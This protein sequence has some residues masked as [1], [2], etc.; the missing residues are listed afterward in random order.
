MLFCGLLEW[1]RQQTTG[2]FASPGDAARSLLTAIVVY[3]AVGGVLGCAALLWRSAAAGAGL[4]LVA[5]AVALLAVIGHEPRPALLLAALS[6][7]FASAWLVM[8]VAART[9][10]L[11]LPRVWWTSLAVLLAACVGLALQHPLGSGLAWGAAFALAALACLDLRSLRGSPR[12]ALAAVGLAVA[13]T[14]FGVAPQRVA[15]P[16]ESA[17]S[18]PSILLVTIDTLRADHVGAYGA[19]QART[20]NIDALALRG[21]RFEYAFSQNAFTAPS[22]SS[23]LSGSLPTTHG[24]QRNAQGRALKVPTLAILEEHGYATAAFPSADVLGPWL[25]GD[26]EYIEPQVEYRFGIPRATFK[27]LLLRPLRRYAREWIASGP[28]RRAPD[29]ARA[30][31]RWLDANQG[32]S[33]FAWV[34]FFDP[35]LP[36]APPVELVQ[37]GVGGEVPPLP[38]WYWLSPEERKATVELPEATALMRAYYDAEIEWVDQA[39]GQIVE[40]AKRSAPEGRLVVAITADHGEAMGEHG[41]WW[42]RDLYDPTIRVPLIIAPEEAPEAAV[43]SEPVRSIDLAPT[44]FELAGVAAPESV[45]GRS[46]VPLM[47]GEAEATSRS[48]LSYSLPET[49]YGRPVASVRDSDWKLIQREAGWQGR[50]H[51]SEREVELYDLRS[52]PGETKNLAAERPD[53]VAPMQSLVDGWRERGGEREE[54]LSEQDREMLRA[55]GYLE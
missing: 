19:T 5:G 46:L 16:A 26:F 53:L 27:L 24:V 54:D 44:L 15:A 52:D 1:L 31:T 50:N 49:E 8:R 33:F 21:T 32:R 2:A 47:R 34:H 30:V 45:D 42:V 25:Y 28:Y 6:L 29:T 18:G 10:V 17:A 51:W 9:P 48:A 11:L 23:I 43:V 37:G 13:L 40:A 20:P 55:L 22:H 14:G 35:H 38:N 12:A 7:A 4:A 3:A 41:L 39:I 36:Y